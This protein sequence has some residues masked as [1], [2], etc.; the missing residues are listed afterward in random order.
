MTC[1]PFHPSSGAR[2][3]SLSF[4]V[5]V[6]ILPREFSACPE[7]FK[8][9]SHPVLGDHLPAQGSQ[10]K[11]SFSQ[12]QLSVPNSSHSALCCFQACA[13]FLEQTDSAGL[14]RA[15]GT[16]LLLQALQA[17]PAGT[18]QHTPVHY[19]L[20]VQVLEATADLS[21]IESC[22]GLLEASLSHVVDMELE[23]PSIH[24]GQH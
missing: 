12:D 19:P 17:L 10:A 8:A 23:V 15:A 16:L 1:F 22:P 7:T 13:Y 4:F 3:G 14:V 5:L 20:L 6:S 18:R 21:S 24:E 9:G 2:W 11:V